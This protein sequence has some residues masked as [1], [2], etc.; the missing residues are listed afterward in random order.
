V[1]QSVI[2][3]GWFGGFTVMYLSKWICVTAV[4]QLYVHSQSLSLTALLR[5]PNPNWYGYTARTPSSP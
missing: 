5:P 4:S 2:F 1:T 3:T